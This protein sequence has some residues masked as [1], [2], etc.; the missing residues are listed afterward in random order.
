MLGNMLIELALEM[1]VEL[2]IEQV[3]E[4]CLHYRYGCSLPVFRG[5]AAAILDKRGIQLQSLLAFKSPR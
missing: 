5:H 1:I 3:F 2:V 4:V